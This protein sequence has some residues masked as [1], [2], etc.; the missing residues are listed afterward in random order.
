MPSRLPRREPGARALV[1]AAKGQ[2]TEIGVNTRLNIAAVDTEDRATLEELLA[3]TVVQNIKVKTR[4]A[5]PKAQ[6]TGIVRPRFSAGQGTQVFNAGHTIRV[7]FDGPLPQWQCGNCGRLGHVR[8]ACITVNVCTTCLEAHKK[9]TCPRADNPSC[10][11]C[12][13]RHDAFDRRCPAYVQARNVGR[14]MGFSGE[15]W[16][17]AKARLARRSAAKRQRRREQPDQQPQEKEVRLKKQSQQQR[18]MQLNYQRQLRH[19]QNQP[20]W[21]RDTHPGGDGEGHWR[22]SVELYPAMPPRSDDATGSAEE[23]E[24]GPRTPTARGG[25]GNRVA[26]LAPVAGGKPSQTLSAPISASTT[27]AAAAVASA[28]EEATGGGTRRSRGS[29]GS[30][31]QSRS[32]SPKKQQ[33]TQQHPAWGY[34]KATSNENKLYDAICN[35]YLTILTDPEHPTRTGNSVTRDTCPDLALIKFT[36]EDWNNM[37]ESLGSDHSIVEIEVSLIPRKDS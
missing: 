23:S 25:G 29:P 2:A 28:P 15:G 12:A 3:V 24:A 10:P 30:E 16:R 18:L 34:L 32:V 17:A 22:P 21:Q 35:H 33:H 27:A 20:A 6:S 19:Q 11:N 4:I 36:A 1:L 31:S 8:A 7:H 5:R 13:Q 37:E 9:G 14:G 26:P